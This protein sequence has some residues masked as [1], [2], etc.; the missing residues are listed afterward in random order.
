MKPP[1]ARESRCVD[2]GKH[3]S[4]ARV[5]RSRLFCEACGR[6]RLREELA[7]RR[8]RTTGGRP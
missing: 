3:M 2:C 1:L 5:A 7:R 4:R 8:R 6:A